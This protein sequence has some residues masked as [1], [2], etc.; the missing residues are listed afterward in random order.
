[1]QKELELHQCEKHTKKIDADVHKAIHDAEKKPSIFIV[2]LTRV[3][4]VAA[5][6]GRSIAEFI[7]FVKDVSYA[8]N[9][10]H[11]NYFTSL[12]L[13]IFS[14]FGLTYVILEICLMTEDM[15]KKEYGTK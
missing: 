9:V 14:L 7:D 3:K 2:I 11:S 4:V 6:Y 10:H 13:W 8:Y 15:F 1:M 5:T 12:L